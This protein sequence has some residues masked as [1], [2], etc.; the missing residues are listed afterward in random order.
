MYSSRHGNVVRHM[1]DF[2]GVGQI[3]QFMDYVIGVRSG[4]YRHPTN[5]HFMYDRYGKPKTVHPLD[6]TD[7]VYE[8]VKVSHNKIIQKFIQKESDKLISTL[9]PNTGQT[10]MSDNNL[11]GWLFGYEASVCNQCNRGYVQAIR[12]Y[13]SERIDYPPHSC[14]P[15]DLETAKLIESS[16]PKKI[17]WNEANELLFKA[18]NNWG[19]KQKLLGSI[20][21]KPTTNSVN[22][23][24]IH[25]EHWASGL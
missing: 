13:G 21:C 25:K 4:T 15:E 3:V 22:L 14:R 23:G 17:K 12:Y 6:P 5:E 9:S 1:N 20:P 2:H 24:V 8:I 16:K 11:E 10:S 18:V 7:I 19:K